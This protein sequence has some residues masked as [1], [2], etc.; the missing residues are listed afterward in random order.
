M[1]HSSVLNL[2]VPTH[3]KQNKAHPLIGFPNKWLTTTLAANPNLSSLSREV[4]MLLPDPDPLVPL[5]C[6]LSPEAREVASDLADAVFNAARS[7]PK[8]ETGLIGSAFMAP[9]K[10]V[11]IVIDLNPSTLER[12]LPED[13]KTGLRN[14]ATINRW[15]KRDN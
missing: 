5:A 14:K 2:C 10:N 13:V 3:T 11:P 7:S 15:M 1:H 8:L 12:Y 4:I 9:E 6:S